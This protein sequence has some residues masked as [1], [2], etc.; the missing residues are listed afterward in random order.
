[1]NQETQPKIIFGLGSNATIINAFVLL[2]IS[3]VFWCLSF[4]KQLPPE[5]N[6]SEYIA[7]NGA[8]YIE[9]I[10]W[11][12]DTPLQILSMIMV[13]Y[14]IEKRYNIKKLDYSWRGIK[15]KFLYP[16]F[17]FTIIGNLIKVLILSIIL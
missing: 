17:G 6:F 11:Y 1:M 15:Y 16:V 8:N 4:F 14:W 9:K 10:P 12:V 7:G 3:Q 5:F 13:L 2:I